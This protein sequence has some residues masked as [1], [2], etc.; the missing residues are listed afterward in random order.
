VGPNGGVGDQTWVAA[1]A[2][3]VESGYF[4]DNS[5]FTFPDNPLPNYANAL[6]PTSGWVTNAILY[7]T[8]NFVSTNINNPQYAPGTPISYPFNSTGPFTYTTNKYTTASYMNPGSYFG[9]PSPEG[10]SGKTN[11]QVITSYTYYLYV[12]NIAWTNMYYDNILVGGP[13]SSPNNYQVSSLSGKTI[14]LGGQ[15]NLVVTG[16][17]SMG[18]NDSIT[19][20]GPP[21]GSASLVMYSGGTSCHIAGNGIINEDGHA[22]SFILYCAPSVT[23]FTLDGNG[24]LIGVVSAPEADAKLNGGGS[25]SIYDLTGAIIAN[26]V[27]MNGHFNFHYDE[28]LGALNGNGRTLAQTWDEIFAGH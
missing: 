14:V 11:Y 18:G 16:G 6:T 10:N 27:T 19:I 7:M 26:T 3:Q 24:G 5:N 9:S 21:S 4:A 25:S 8:T 22:A 17:L 12:T 2:G 13:S 1:H 20:V 23:S 28:S 15:V